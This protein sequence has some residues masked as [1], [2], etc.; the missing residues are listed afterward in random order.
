MNCDKSQKKRM[1]LATL[2]IFCVRWI[3]FG[4]PFLIRKSM[5]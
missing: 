5:R 1:I 2:W 3:D 4:S